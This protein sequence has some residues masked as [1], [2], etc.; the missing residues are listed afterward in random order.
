MV[1]LTDFLPTL[2]DVAGLND[3]GVARDGVSF[4][5]MLSTSARREN[6]HGERE[7]IFIQ[8]RGK[9]CILS[10]NRKV[11]G[12]GRFFDL[13]NDPGELSPLSP[14][15]RTEEMNESYTELT[16]ILAGLKGPLGRF[17]SR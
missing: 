13:V 5:S 8:H 15:Q 1:D 3:D 10:R 6:A 11:Y 12:D 2:A 7:W 17:Q 4:A 9:R 16:S 14:N